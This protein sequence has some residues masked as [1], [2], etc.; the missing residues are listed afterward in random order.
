MCLP[1][2][3]Q[4]SLSFPLNALLLPV[5]KSRISD[6]WSKI[7]TLGKNKL[8]QALFVFPLT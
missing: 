7:L 3:V 6:L 4:D 2:S 5:G 8:K 1:I